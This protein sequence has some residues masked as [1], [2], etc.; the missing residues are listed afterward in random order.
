MQSVVRQLAPGKECAATSAAAGGRGAL[1]PWH[2]L[3][4][5]V[6]GLPFRVLALCGT[7]I[8]LLLLCAHLPVPVSFVTASGRRRCWI[9]RTSIWNSVFIPAGGNVIAN[10]RCVWT[11]WG[12]GGGG[13]ACAGGTQSDPPSSTRGG[14]IQAASC[15]SVC[16]S[17]S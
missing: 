11:R 15:G 2:L 16:V 5:S 10:V 6:S 4:L 12:D 9:G 1:Y 7:F 13:H 3:L 17:T 14:Q 8:A